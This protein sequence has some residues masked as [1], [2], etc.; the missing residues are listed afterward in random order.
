MKKFTELSEEEKFPWLKKLF[1][2]MKLT[3]FLILISVVCVFASKTYSQSKMHN[4]NMKNASVKEVLSKI[5]DL[6]EFKFMYSGKV[7]DV[8]REVS[9]NTENAKIE[10]VLKSLFAGTDVEYT[11]KDRIIVLTASGLSNSEL[12]VV[13]QQKSVSGKVTDSAGS[14]LPGVSVVIKGTTNGTITDVNGNYSISNVSGNTVLQFSFV[15]MKTQE[16]AVAGKSNLNILLEEETV[17]I[18][19][20]VAVGYG[21]QK[22]VSMTGSVSSVDS[23]VLE[24]RPVTSITV[25]LQGAAPGLIVQRYSGQPGNAGWNIDVRGASSITS[26]P[27]LVLI[28]GIQGNMDLLNPND[29]E[30]MS[31]LKDASAS[32]YGARAAG[33]VILITTKKGKTGAA[34]ITYSVNIATTKVTG[35]M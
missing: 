25:A 34:Q 22:K 10:D 4:L 30:S 14:P 20:V 6:S 29:I 15:G 28:D 5:E 1:R 33:G 7:V 35:M 23:K 27:P 18:E 21:V 24:S 19:E 26:T 17:G 13:Q 8:N 9:L 32:I 16:I 3:T 2:I 12:F 31:I 11:I